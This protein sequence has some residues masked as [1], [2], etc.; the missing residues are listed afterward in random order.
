MEYLEPKDHQVLME[1]QEL[2]E[3]WGRQDLRDRP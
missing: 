3:T 2:M 1:R